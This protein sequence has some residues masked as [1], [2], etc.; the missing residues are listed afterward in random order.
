LY[1]YDV[2]TVEIG[3]LVS[4]L[5]RQLD[6]VRDRPISTSDDLIAAWSI[7]EAVEEEFA[8]LFE[9]EGTGTPELLTAF[10]ESVSRINRA[11]QR[12]RRVEASPAIRRDAA[13]QA[14]VHVSG[15]RRALVLV[16]FEGDPSMRR[17]ADL[18]QMV[19]RQGVVSGSVDKCVARVPESVLMTL[20]SRNVGVFEQVPG[21]P[22]AELL[23]CALALWDPYYED[24]EFGTFEAALTAA[25]RIG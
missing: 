19:L 23:E 12:L 4:N 6:D 10:G 17:L 16:A 8:L 14:G 15:T 5:Y 2:D 18:C 20:M 3:I 7:L 9:E 13:E 11:E 22:G 21:D 25:I 24:S 1:V